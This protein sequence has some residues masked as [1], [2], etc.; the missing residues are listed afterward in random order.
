MLAVKFILL[1]LSVFIGYL[2]GYLF[3][4]KWNIGRF[5]IFDF[6]GFKCRQC[7][8]FHIAWVTS[9]IISLLFADWTMLFVGIGFAFMLFIGLKI[10]QKRKTVDVNNY[11]LEKK[12]NNI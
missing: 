2:G 6:E 9:T 3:A 1:V 4:E 11:H 10:D 12:E 8:S 5:K 7:L